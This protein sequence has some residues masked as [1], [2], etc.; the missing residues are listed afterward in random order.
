MKYIITSLL[1]I[2]FYY[3]LQPNMNFVASGINYACAFICAIYLI[4]CDK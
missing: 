2:N 1:T 3:M 4:Y